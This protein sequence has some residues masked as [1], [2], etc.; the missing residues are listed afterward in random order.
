MWQIWI[1]SSQG[2][3]AKMPLV[4]SHLWRDA[5]HVF[6][7][8]SPLTMG[9]K[10]VPPLLVNAI[11]WW[12]PCDKFQADLIR[13]RVHNA[14]WLICVHVEDVQRFWNTISYLKESFYEKTTTYLICSFR[15]A[16]GEGHGLSFPPLL[17]LFKG[18]SR[19]DKAFQVFQD[20]FKSLN[21]SSLIALCF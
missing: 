12:A 9:Q 2:K 10:D 17:V 7:M 6:T 13:Q 21:L 8:K 1:K 4:T 20:K 16:C 11:W 3:V 15:Y 5:S 19:W 18:E 14:P